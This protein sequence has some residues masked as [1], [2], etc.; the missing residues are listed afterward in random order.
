MRPRLL[1]TYLFCCTILLEVTAQ[2]QIKSTSTKTYDIIKLIFGNPDYKLNS[3]TSWDLESYDTLGRVRS[4]RKC[5]PHQ[6]NGRKC[7]TTFFTFDDLGRITVK[8]YL[9]EE[10]YSTDQIILITQRKIERRYNGLDS[11]NYVQWDYNKDGALTE[12][13]ISVYNN[14]SSIRTLTN[15]NNLGQLITMITTNYDANNRLVKQTYYNGTRNYKTITWEYSNNNRL[16]VKRTLDLNI[17]TEYTRIDSITYLN[18]ARFSFQRNFMLTGPG[19]WILQDELRYNYGSSGSIIVDYRKGNE[20]NRKIYLSDDW[21]LDKHKDRLFQEINYTNQVPQN[22][23]AYEYKLDANS[24]WLESLS[25]EP[26]GP[27]RVKKPKQLRLRTLSY[28]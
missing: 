4:K 16:E 7:E 27:G 15:Y 5:V 3:Y 14:N 11:L 26:L 22:E 1:F 13:I 20:L 18:D 21:Y 28:H 23:T 2:A 8:E 12:K 10:T 24:Y 17:S 9:S 6:T 19:T 25:Y